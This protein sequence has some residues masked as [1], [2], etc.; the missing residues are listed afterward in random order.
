M[1]ERFNNFNF[2]KNQKYNVVYKHEGWQGNFSGVYLG[3]AKGGTYLWFETEDRENKKSN[4]R[5]NNYDIVF[6]IGV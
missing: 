4:C 1:G 6:A 5:F 3:S 2:T